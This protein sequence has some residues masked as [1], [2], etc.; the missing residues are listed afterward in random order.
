MTGAVWGYN[1]SEATDDPCPIRASLH[2][3]TIQKICR[4]TRDVPLLPEGRY[5]VS[6]Y[7]PTSGTYSPGILVAGGKAVMLALPRW[8]H[9]TVIRATRVN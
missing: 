5:R 1:I 8:R 6:L 9:D 7:S 3:H 4:P 2:E